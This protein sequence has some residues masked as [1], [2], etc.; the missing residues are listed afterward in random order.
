[1]MSLRTIQNLWSYEDK[2]Q[3][4]QKI[5]DQAAGLY[6]KFVGLI[7]SLETVGK[8]LTK[9]EESYTNAHKQLT[10][11]RGNLIDRAE[12]LR[13]LGVTPKKRISPKLID[14]ATVQGS[15]PMIPTMSNNK[16]STIT[17]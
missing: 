9:A 10:S 16:E 8:H 5:A 17:H 13:D 3:N 2:N 4:A 11:G 6:D 15:E 12:K 7:D 14:D 1:M